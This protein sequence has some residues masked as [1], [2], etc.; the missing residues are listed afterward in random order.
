[1]RGGRAKREEVFNVVFTMQ[2]SR[3]VSIARVLAS[4]RYQDG[5]HV[6]IEC[7][8]THGDV[9]PRRYDH[10]SMASKYP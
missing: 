2:G 6:V 4:W 8:C 3:H 1:M 5:T 7:V 9:D 10:R